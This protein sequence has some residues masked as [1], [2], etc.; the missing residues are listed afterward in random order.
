MCGISG[1]IDRCATSS[2]DAQ[3]LR[4]CAKTRDV[5]GPISRSAEDTALLAAA[6]AGFASDDVT[7]SSENV[8]DYKFYSSSS[9]L[10]QLSIGYDPA[11]C[12]AINDAQVRALFVSTSNALADLG[13]RLITT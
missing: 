1:V 2:I 13:H 10:S 8:S 6:I 3:Q 11:I 7:T 5:I 9:K 4:R 12:A